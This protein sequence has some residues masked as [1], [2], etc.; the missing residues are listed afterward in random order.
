M[1]KYEDTDAC[2]RR[3]VRRR[4]LAAL[5]LLAALKLLMST[6]GER[7]WTG[8]LAQFW[9]A[10]CLSHRLPQDRIAY[11]AAPAGAALPAY[12]G[13]F[14][15]ASR[16]TWPGTVGASP[17][18]IELAEY[19]TLTGAAGVPW[20]SMPGPVFLHGLRDP[21][22]R[23]RLV[24]VY[25]LANNPSGWWTLVA[26]VREPL[27]FGAPAPN[28][29]VVS[30]ACWPLA[31]VAGGVFAVFAGQPD[32]K[33]PARFTLRVRVNGRDQTVSGALRDDGTVSF[34]SSTGLSP[35]ST[36]RAGPIVVRV[37]TPPPVDPHD[38]VL[39]PT[40]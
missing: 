19:H 29:P 14:S 3:V 24:T 38:G 28:A 5:A 11:V 8:A 16:P 25:A 40:D 34:A 2:R 10:R 30:T 1:L 4:L 31:T 36:D 22:G 35:W 13:D 9:Q 17:Y 32:L 33:D 7:A 18:P 37:I 21:S 26:C 20:A 23:R 6:A 27:A 39:L 15:D 12:L